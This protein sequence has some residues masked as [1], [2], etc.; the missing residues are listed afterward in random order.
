MSIVLLPTWLCWQRRFSLSFSVSFQVGTAPEGSCVSSGNQKRSSCR[1]VL[2]VT[3]EPK[4]AA[5]FQDVLSL[6]S[7][8][9]LAL[10]TK[11]DPRPPLDALATTHRDGSQ[12]EPTAFTELVSPCPQQQCVLV[13]THSSCKFW[14]V[15]DLSLLLQQHFSDIYLPSSSNN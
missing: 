5:A 15:H 2:E 11:S 7:F 4:G 6:S 3:V 12:E 1:Y 13:Y 8:P 10:P 14:L 9:M